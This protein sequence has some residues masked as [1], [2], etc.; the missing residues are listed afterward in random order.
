MAKNLF[1]A[2]YALAIIIVAFCGCKKFEK[3]GHCQEPGI[4]LSFD[5]DRVDNWF[6]HLAFLDSSGVKATFYI[7]K[8]NRFT[9]DQ[10]ENWV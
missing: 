6:E 9:A 7:C 1:K 10:K 8:Y 3:E 4:V 5:D 2:S